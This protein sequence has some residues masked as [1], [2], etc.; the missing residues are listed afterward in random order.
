MARPPKPTAAK[1]EQGTLRPHRERG[2]GPEPPPLLEVPKAPE[3]LSDRARKTWDV[4]APLLVQRRLLA[5]GDLLLLELLSR[6][7]A[8]YLTLAEA[9]EEEGAS[10][11][12]AAG[13]KRNPNAVEMNAAF[14]NALACLRDFG[15]TPSARVKV[16]GAA[17]TPAANPWD[18]LRLFPGGKAS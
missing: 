15:L 12:T 14:K 11:E 17:E 8:R 18:K 6:E 2:K 4:Y 10:I 5:A 1:A 16:R 3:G 9:V 13:P 7:W